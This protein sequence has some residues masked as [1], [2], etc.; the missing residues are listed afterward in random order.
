MALI[1]NEIFYSIQGESLYA[2]L[3]CVFIRLTG[4]NLRCTY[5]D[6]RY[7]YKEGTTLEIPE[8]L[9]RLAGYS[10]GLVEIT[11]GEPLHQ[12][13]T[14]LLVKRLIAESYTVLLET[15]GSYD[16][17]RLDHRCIKIL[18]IK[19]PG[20]GENRQNRLDN[21]KHLRRT[22]QVKFVIGN[23]ED[24]IFAK[25]IVKLIPDGLPQSH[26]LFSPVHEKITAQTLAEWILQDHLGVRL[27]LQLHKILWPNSHRGV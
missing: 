11:G 23:R 27:H 2:G 3:P 16:I 14:P 4:C 21:L 5:C 6:T 24:Y 7:A 15:N 17:R 26:I 13:E 25:D 19:C 8:I 9:D 10:C 22:D 18:D 1:V 20:S 12:Q